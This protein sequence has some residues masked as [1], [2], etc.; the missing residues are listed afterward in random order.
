MTPQSQMAWFAGLSVR[1][2]TIVLCA[3][4]YRFSII[5]RDLTVSPQNERTIPRLHG[6]G[7]MLHRM[8]PYVVAL[9]HG[10]E[11]RFPD[12]E[13]IRVLFAAADD[14]GLNSVFEPAWRSAAAQVVAD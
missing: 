8:M 11:K 1:N 7:E 3:L 6:V 14:Y 12:E 4:A 13:L 5:I 10:N 9:H 2:K